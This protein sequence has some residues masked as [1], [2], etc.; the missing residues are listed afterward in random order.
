MNEQYKMEQKKGI[1]HNPKKLKHVNLDPVLLQQ[2]PLIQRANEEFIRNRKKTKINP[3]TD[4]LA[5]R[6]F[7]FHMR[8]KFIEYLSSEVPNE[9]QYRKYN[10]KPNYNT[11]KGIWNNLN[12][13]F[14]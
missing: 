1:D 8:D 7:Y 4:S 12:S 6:V 14:K 10:R 13:K 2:T 5:N 11:F 3:T 9:V